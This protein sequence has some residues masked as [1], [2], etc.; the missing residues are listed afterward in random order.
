[1]GRIAVAVM[2]AVMLGGC[3]RSPADELVAAAR[4][5][6]YRPVAG[7]LSGLPYAMLPPA[8]RASVPS[9]RAKLDMSNAFRL[10]GMQQSDELRARSLVLLGELDDAKNLFRKMTSGR[11]VP[12]ATWSDYAATLHATADP[13]DALQL[14]MA[15]A[16]TDRALDLQPT[17]PAAL[18]NRAIILDALALRGE[19]AIACKRYLDVDSSSPWAAETRERLRQIESARSRTTAWQDIVDDLERAAEAGDEL[20]IN[21]VATSYPEEARRQADFYLAR[22]AE[23]FLAKDR[24]GAASMLLLCRIIGRALED[25]CGDSL[26]ADAVRAI[27]ANAGSREH[28]ARA[29]IAYERGRRAM[30]WLDNARAVRA[31]ADARK[32]FSEHGSPMAGPAA[33]YRAIARRDHSPVFWGGLEPTKPRGEQ[34]DPA[35]LAGPL[36]MLDANER[37]FTASLCDLALNTPPRYRALHAEIQWR[38]ALH[39][40]H[41]GPHASVLQSIR[42]ATAT[43]E[44]L[45]EKRSAVATRDAIA[46]LLARSGDTNSA[47]RMRHAVMASAAEAGDDFRLMN[48]TNRAARDAIYDG[49]WDIAFSLLNVVAG[50]SNPDLRS[51]EEAIVWSALAAN[52]AGMLRASGAALAQA[53]ATER[54]TN[55]L[56]MVEALVAVDKGETVSLLTQS[57][58]STDSPMA[59][60]RLLV[61]RARALRDMHE[62]ARAQDDLERAVKLLESGSLLTSPDRLRDAAIGSPVDAFRLLADELDRD[63]DSTR[64]QELLEHFRTWP[65]PRHPPSR[66]RLLTA[67]SSTV[68]I[69]YGLFEGRIVIYANNL[70]A[71][72]S[73]SAADVERLATAFGESI[74]QN[75]TRRFKDVGRQLLCILFDPIA[76]VAQPGDTLVFVSDAALARLPF[77]ALMLADGRY[78][79][80]EHPVVITPTRTAWLQS[81]HPEA[82]DLS[83]TAVGGESSLR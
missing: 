9:T 71:T 49:R 23:R 73:V 62:P 61:A 56:Q 39:A 82:N 18:F 83:C 72:V 20:F 37:A 12:A 16:A 79:I 22:W 21:D 32:Q 1:M 5:L 51:R 7:R 48:V 10:I 76:A 31:L 70:R 78:L 15:L 4:T 3:G 43:F 2:V 30:Q 53:R 34:G 33:L 17:L 50:E 58:R 64:A 46:G 28:L 47:W 13:D 44:A 57:L 75:D 60:A 40:R 67:P 29:Q 19:A 66:I 41:S 54:L 35:V 59:T 11:D 8:G 69:S 77:G 42:S 74:D 14:A 63:G 68:V 25:S 26:L 6:E 27:D 24:D 65:T 36:A 52:R 38:L 81:L 45:G 55:D 80:E